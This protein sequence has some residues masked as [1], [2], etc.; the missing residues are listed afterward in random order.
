MAL[1]VVR[2]KEVEVKLLTPSQNAEKQSHATK[3]AFVI[4]GARLETPLASPP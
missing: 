4:V 1:V 3:L 2:E